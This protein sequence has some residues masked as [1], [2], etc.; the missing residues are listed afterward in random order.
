MDR[1]RRHN[2]EARRIVRLTLAAVAHS[3]GLTEADLLV[4]DRHP[5]AVRARHQAWAAC[6]SLGLTLKAIADVGGWDH[7]TVREG[8]IKGGEQ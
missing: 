6:R 3:H 8:A 2:A 4:R 1:A 5:R 7:S